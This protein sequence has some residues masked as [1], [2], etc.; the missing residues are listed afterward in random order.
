MSQHKKGISQPDECYKFCSIT[1]RSSHGLQR[2]T[3]IARSTI[4]KS[5]GQM[6]SFEES[7]R[8][9]SNDKFCL[10]I[11]LA[12]H[13]L[14]GHDRL[15]KETSKLFN[16]ILETTGGTDRANFR[17]ICVEDIAAVEDIV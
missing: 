14:H 17:S 9:P 13:H 1:Q 16:L 3:C 4:Q 10:F 2:S 11:A 7:T 5:V 6:S 12:L 15:E 8:K